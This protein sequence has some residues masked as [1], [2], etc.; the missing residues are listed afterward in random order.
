MPPPRVVREE[1]KKEQEEGKSSER[2]SLAESSDK[3]V[4]AG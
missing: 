4:A 2:G 3:A 1:G